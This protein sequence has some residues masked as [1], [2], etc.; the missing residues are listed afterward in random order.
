MAELRAHLI[1]PS[2]IYLARLNRKC[3]FMSM[4]P[5]N[6][7]CHC[8]LDQENKPHCL[9]L[10]GSRKRFH[11]HKIKWGAYGRLR[12]IYYLYA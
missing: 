2:C 6:L 8:F 9:V 1:C 12:F 7:G 5:I 11:N 10:V 4:N 3:S